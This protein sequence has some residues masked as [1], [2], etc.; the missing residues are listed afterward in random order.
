MLCFRHRKTLNA[1]E[2]M[3]FDLEYDYEEA[4]KRQEIDA[5][6]VDLLR[7]AVAD[8]DVIPKTMTNKQVGTH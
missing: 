6:D 1:L 4:L 5:K 2:M 3:D 8:I 7:L